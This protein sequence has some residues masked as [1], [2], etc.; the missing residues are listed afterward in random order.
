MD[1]EHFIPPM[2]P[3]KFKGKNEF[4]Y[5]VGA[6]DNVKEDIRWR[7]SFQLVINLNK[8]K[9]TNLKKKRNR[10]PR[11]KKAGINLVNVEMTKV[12]QKSLKQE[13]RQMLKEAWLLGCDDSTDKEEGDISV[14]SNFKQFSVQG[15]HVVIQWP[16]RQKTKDARSVV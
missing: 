4:L 11:V 9:N 15:R 16:T 6:K 3:P 10:K 7:Y 5:Y 1:K 2:I 13:R 14:P 12:K 8:D